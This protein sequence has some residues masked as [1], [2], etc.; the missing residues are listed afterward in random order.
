MTSHISD[1]QTTDKPIEYAEALESAEAGNTEQALVYMQE[2]LAS[3]PNDPEALNDTGAILFSLGHTQE[4]LNHL[5]KARLLDPD[6]AEIVWNLVET[7]LAQNDGRTAMTCFD[8]MERL[9][10]L[11][12]DVLNRTADVLLQNGDLAGAVQTLERSLAVS[13][14]QAILSNMIEVIRSKM[15]GSNS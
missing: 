13:P 14:D 9:E 2:F 15:S 10:I 7:A 12:A 5:S 3:A 1:T 8:D 4:A 6:S 11:N